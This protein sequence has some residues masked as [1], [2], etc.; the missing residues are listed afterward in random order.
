MNGKNATSQRCVA[1]PHVRRFGCRSPDSAYASRRSRR[2][3]WA[4]YAQQGTSGKYLGGIRTVARQRNNSVLLIGGCQQQS[5]RTT[6]VVAHQPVAII[7]S[8]EAVPRSRDMASSRHQTKTQPLSWLWPITVSIHESA[9][10]SW[11]ADAQI[12]HKQIEGGKHPGPHLGYAREVRSRMRRGRGANADDRAR[13]PCGTDMLGSG[14]G[15]LAL[16]LRR[17]LNVL[18]RAAMVGLAPRGS[19]PL[20]PPSRADADD[21]QSRPTSVVRSNAA[22][23]AIAVDLNENGK[24]HLML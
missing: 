9:M 4:E 15:S 18:R 2:R 3:G 19:L 7:V 5:Q 20:P 23:M 12:V 1:R 14:N 11:G 16:L 8:C 13:D 22:A 24:R 10:S 6:R 17:P 21:R